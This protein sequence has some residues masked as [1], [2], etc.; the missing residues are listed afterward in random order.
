MKKQTLSQCLS[1]G[2][3]GILQLLIFL[4]LISLSCNKVSQG[5]I[6]DTKDLFLPTESQISQ[7]LRS[8]E[9]YRVLDDFAKSKGFKNA[10][11]YHE[12]L[13]RE[14]EDEELQAYYNK[15]KPSGLE[16]LGVEALANERNKISKTEKQN[17]Y[18][19]E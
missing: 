14:I 3:G 1:Q 15:Y 18:T 8:K 19:D 10:K 17:R 12:K 5:K 6:T 16:N 11:E 7:V 9:D 2:A 13:I 4:I